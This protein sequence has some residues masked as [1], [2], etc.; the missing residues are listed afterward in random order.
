M[1]SRRGSERGTTGTPAWLAVALLATV[2]VIALAVH[3]DPVAGA[4]IGVAALAAFGVGGLV[5]YLVRDGG[6]PGRGQPGPHVTQSEAATP[7]QSSGLAV[8][9]VAE[10]QD[11]PSRD[12]TVHPPSR[13]FP[14]CADCG[15]CRD[16][17]WVSD[18]RSGGQVWICFVCDPP[19]PDKAA[20]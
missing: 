7:H 14:A 11:G 17:S 5:A 9:H 4:A 2:A 16:G 20:A 1:T 18:W 3:Y 12:R 6:K 15:I 8:V 19:P 13:S 10:P